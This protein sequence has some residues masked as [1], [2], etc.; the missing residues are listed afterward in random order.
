MGRD[1][2][3]SSL[4]SKKRAREGDFSQDP[5][6][7]DNKEHSEVSYEVLQNIRLSSSDQSTSES[8]EWFSDIQPEAATGAKSLRTQST[9]KCEVV[10]VSPPSCYTESDASC[11]EDPSSAAMKLQFFLSPSIVKGMIK[12]RVNGSLWLDLES[13]F[14]AQHLPPE[15]TMFTLE[16]EV[17]KCHQVKYVACRAELSSGWKEFATSHNLSAGDVLVFHLT[18]PSK[19]KIYIFRTNHREEVEG[20][21]TRET[22]PEKLSFAK[23]ATDD[24]DSGSTCSS[25]NIEWPESDPPWISFRESR[26]CFSKGGSFDHESG[27]HTF[28]LGPFGPIRDFTSFKDQLLRDRAPGV[29]PVA[30]KFLDDFVLEDYYKLCLAQ[31]NFLHRDLYR[32][33]PQMYVDAVID[34]I[35]YRSRRLTGLLL[36]D[37]NLVELEDAKLFLK[38]L[39][40]EGFAVGFM[41]KFVGRLLSFKEEPIWLEANLKEDTA[42]FKEYCGLAQNE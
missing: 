25:N 42:C 24:A 27:S 19:F 22:I 5:S 38:E 8:C 41:T 10:N 7:L 29:R 14:C 26:L 30:D 6:G 31:G 21:H 36:V 23:E 33:Q 40:D 32:K 28:F 17:G 4:V 39:E 35:V 11:D 13:S 1:F 34:D 12:P 15:D 2:G 9:Q 16:D 37:Y 3:N 20:V 18:N